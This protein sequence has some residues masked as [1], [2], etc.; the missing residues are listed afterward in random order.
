MWKPWKPQLFMNG[1]DGIE[2]K[3]RGFGGEAA[4]V[5]MMQNLI[6]IKHSG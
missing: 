2:R 4:R 5:S 6:V 1:V 3:V